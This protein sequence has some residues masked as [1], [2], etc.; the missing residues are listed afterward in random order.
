MHATT[1]LRREGVAT[2]SLARSKLG[3]AAVEFR[4]GLP[5]D[6]GLVRNS[7]VMSLTDALS[8][9]HGRSWQ[10][11]HP[12]ADAWL[13]TPER[14]E[15]FLALESWEELVDSVTEAIDELLGSPEVKSAAVTEV[16]LRPPVVG[17]QKIVAVGLNYPSHAAE[18]DREVPEYP[19]LFAKFANTLTG[20]TDDIPIPPASHRI[21]YEGE[22]AVV[23]GRRTRRVTREEADSAIAGYVVANDVSARD[24]QFR[25][26]EML[27]GKTFDGFCP[28]GPWISKPR[29]A[30]ELGDLALTTRVN[31]EVRQSARLAE[32][33]FDVPYLVG[34]VSQIMTLLP[35]DL[36]LT[37]T[38]AGIGATMK[39]RRWLRDGDTV[40]VEI[41]GIGQITNRFRDFD[42]VHQAEPAK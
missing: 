9:I 42:G 7:T 10:S 16:R 3:L 14:L 4:D 26:K 23:I 40:D 36:I 6:A 17:P 15:S 29:A 1:G 39:P 19:V 21:D 41:S 8:A 20:P 32:M 34:Y 25:T 31:G 38:P 24:F 12:G 27:Q 11:A 35:G 18:A 28:L 5:A 13:R 37:G 30:D 2:V 22:L 33:I